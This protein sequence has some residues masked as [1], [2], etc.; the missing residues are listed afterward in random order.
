MGCV[1]NGDDLSYKRCYLLLAL[2]GT[3]VLGGV[4]NDFL[5]H[6]THKTLLRLDMERH[7]AFWKLLNAHCMVSLSGQHILA[8]MTFIL[9]FLL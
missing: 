6:Y 9:V 8:G 2:G 4:S 7:C 1:I 5:F 3:D